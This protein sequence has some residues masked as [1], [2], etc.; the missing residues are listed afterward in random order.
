MSG[1]PSVPDLLGAKLRIGHSLDGRTVGRCLAGCGAA[2]VRAAIG[3]LENA[4]LREHWN[5]TLP[6]PRRPRPGTQ[7]ELLP[8]QDAR[9]DPSTAP[10][11]VGF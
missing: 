7:L 1:L 10:F 8:V 3:R 9:H 11:P 4:W 5:E 6:P 2:A